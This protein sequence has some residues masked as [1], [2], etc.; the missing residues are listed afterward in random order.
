MWQL[1]NR[2][3]STTQEDENNLELMTGNNIVSNPIEI[4][5]KL[6]MYFTNTVA[7]LVQQN[8]NKGRYNNSRQ[9]INHCPNSIFISPV[10]ED[11][12]VSLAKH[13]KDKLTA[14][15]CSIRESLV[16]QYIQLIKGH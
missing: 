13:L 16:K 5:E 6:N 9:E 10:T 14:G 2:E 11:E 3:I 4:A 1:T 15:Y 8:I 12:V 7:E